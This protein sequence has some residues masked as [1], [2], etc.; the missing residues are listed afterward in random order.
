MKANIWPGHILKFFLKMIY[1]FFW[2]MIYLWYKWYI[3]FMRMNIC[4][5]VCMCATCVSGACGGQN[6]VLGP[7]E[8]ELH[9]SAGNWSQVL[10][11][12]SSALLHLW[13][14]YSGPIFYLLSDCGEAKSWKGTCVVCKDGGLELAVPVLK[15]EGLLLRKIQSSVVIHR[16]WLLGAQKEANCNSYR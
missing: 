8:P 6:G 13:A 14:I 1:L 15:G 5:H 4:L 7:L 2:Y 12:R 16:K 9:V 11:K 3:Y 10:G